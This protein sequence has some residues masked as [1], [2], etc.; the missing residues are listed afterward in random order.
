MPSSAPATSTN[1][2]NYGTEPGRA[3]LP[4]LEHVEARRRVVTDWPT[5][6]WRPTTPEESEETPPGES[7][8]DNRPAG[9]APRVDRP[10]TTPRRTATPGRFWNT[11]PPSERSRNQPLAVVHAAPAATALD[12]SATQPDGPPREELTT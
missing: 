2:G 7:H 10:P 9:R 4:G 6:G 11:S 12:R 8:S 3:A 5:P 1:A